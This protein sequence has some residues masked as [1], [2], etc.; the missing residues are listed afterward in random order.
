MLY[1]LFDFSRN[2]VATMGVQH[3]I[4]LQTV[5]ASSFAQEHLNTCIASFLTLISSKA[6]CGAASY[7]IKLDSALDYT[8]PLST[9]GFFAKIESF[10]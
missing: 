7:K 6:A 1:L 9:I 2:Y 3:V 4:R 8:F 5:L 10:L